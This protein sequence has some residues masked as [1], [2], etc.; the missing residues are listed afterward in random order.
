MRVSRKA[1]AAVN[2]LDAVIRSRKAIRAFKSEP[3]P[4]H[5][6]TEIL[7]AA[8]AAPSNFNSSLGVFICWR[9]RQRML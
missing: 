9:V 2:I 7:D 6:L 4:K 1:E 5:L 3:V 8:R